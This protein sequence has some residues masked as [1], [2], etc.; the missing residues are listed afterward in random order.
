MIEPH[1]STLTLAPVNVD[2]GPLSQRDLRVECEFSRREA[3][4]IIKQLQSALGPYAKSCLW[5]ARQECHR[6]ITGALSAVLPP[7]RSTR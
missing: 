7:V 3:R 2:S 1:L 4:E 6:A 5:I